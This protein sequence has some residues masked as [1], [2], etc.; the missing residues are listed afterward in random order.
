[1]TSASPGNSMV[2]VYARRVVESTLVRYGALALLFL[3]QP[4]REA[5]RV[6]AFSNTDVWLHIRSGLWMLQQHAVPRNGIFSQLPG[7]MWIASNWLYEAGLGA[8]YQFFGIRSIPIILM[9]LQLV[10]AV[11][12]FLLARGGRDWFWRPALLCAAAQ[13]VIGDLQPVPRT[14]SVLFFAIELMILLHSRRSQRSMPLFLLPVLFLVW[15][16]A[17]EQFLLGLGILG[18]YI[19]TL[20]TER[21]ASRLSPKVEAVDTTFF[22]RALFAGGA[23]FLAT[24]LTPYSYRLY[25]DAFR[26]A[27]NPV[28]YQYF[29]LMQALPFRKLQHTAFLFLVMAA[30]FVL[31]R[32][33]KR[34]HF[35]LAILTASACLSFRFQRDGWCVALIAVAILGDSLAEKL[36][37]P[38]AERNHRA[39]P[40]IAALIGVLIAVFA[41]ATTRIPSNTELMRRARNFMPFEAAEYIR[42]HQLPGP[43]FNSY[44]WGGFLAFNLPEYPVVI[45]SR[46]EL[47][48]DQYSLQYFR[49]V[50]GKQR[51]ETFP[52]F[53]GAQTIILERSSGIAEALTTLPALQAQFRVVYQDRQAVVLVRNQAQPEQ[54]SL[55]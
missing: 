5:M 30:F 22:A 10:F 35:K 2:N 51:L 38:Q 7:G 16:N 36:P 18:L 9:G 53:V 26:S 50:E 20:W 46:M 39:W 11:L 3:V 19:A 27:Y 17:D 37:Q 55:Q 14:V 52:N 6:S 48:G 24:L 33:A 28:L 1:M 40:A 32:A 25:A 15:A 23:A 34:D 45:D 47:Y 12:V 54:P 42:Q 43:L 8:A 31:G 29:D 13:F 4:V 44:G 41:V 21:V 49:I